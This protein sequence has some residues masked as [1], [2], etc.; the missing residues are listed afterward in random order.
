MCLFP[1]VFSTSPLQPWKVIVCWEPTS[2]VFLVWNLQRLNVQVFLNILGAEPEQFL[3]F[4]S[5]CKVP[6]VKCNNSQAKCTAYQSASLIFPEEYKHWSLP[7]DDRKDGEGRHGSFGDPCWS[8]T[9]VC[10]RRLPRWTCFP[11]PPCQAWLCDFTRPVGGQGR[12]HE[13]FSAW[14]VRL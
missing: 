12:Q 14:A 4:P 5:G 13:P 11:V 1:S 10:A 9:E 8:S 3:P 6:Y 7:R 2:P